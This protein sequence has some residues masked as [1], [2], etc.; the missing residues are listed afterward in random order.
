MMPAHDAVVLAAGG[1]HRLGQPKQLLTRDGETLVRRCVRLALETAPR[2]LLVI[3]GGHAEAVTAAVRDLPMDILPNPAWE[4]GLAS[5]LRLAAAT[6]VSGRAD[7]S[8]ACL[9]LACDQPALEAAHLDALREGFVARGCAATRHGDGR[10]V[11]AWAPADLLAQAASLRGD[12]GL[13]G[14]FAVRAPEC[15]ALLDAPE[16]THDIDTPEDLREARR[17]GWIDPAPDC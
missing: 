15:I 8:P 9:L 5:S 13:R 3:V 14:L 12:R 7:A 4:E 6:L 16:L 11:P 1:S 10:G 17:R 2:R